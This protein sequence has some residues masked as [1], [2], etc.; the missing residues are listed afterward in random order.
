MGDKRIRE[1]SFEVK[2]QVVGFGS[3]ATFWG[4]WISW[5]EDGISFEREIKCFQK[6]VDE[7]R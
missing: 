4:R 3:V 1:K 6:M 5:D 7:R 2:S